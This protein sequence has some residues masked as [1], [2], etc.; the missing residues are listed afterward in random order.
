MD[1]VKL[2]PGFQISLWAEG[3]PNARSITVGDKGTVFVGSRLVGNV[4]AVV[5]KG[6]RR[7]VKIL[8]KGLHRPN[9]VAFKDGTLYMAELSRILRFDDIENRLDESPSPVVIFDKLPKDEP[10]GWKFMGLGP[11][12]KLYFNIGAP[13]NICEPPPAVH[14]SYGS[15]QMGVAMKC[16]RVASAIA[17]GWT[18]TRAPRSC[19]S[20]ITAAIG[21]ATRRPTT[22]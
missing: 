21:W 12:G 8:A 19:T 7:E 15:I 9:G 1:K 2:P 16:S 14:R 22:S 6:D 20:P 10:H 4:Y 18:G 13:C 17:W 3:I 11:D 5:D